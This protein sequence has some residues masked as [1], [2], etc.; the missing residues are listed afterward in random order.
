MRFKWVDALLADQPEMDRINF[1]ISLKAVEQDDGCWV[2][3]GWLDE[4][5]YGHTG[6]HGNS[7]PVHAASWIAHYGS[8]FP[9]D[10]EFDHL[11]RNRACCRPSHLEPV[12][13][14]TNIRRGETGK[15]QRDKTHCPQGHEYTE[16]NTRL[17]GGKYRVCRT[18]HRERENKRY[19]NRRQQ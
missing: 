17:K 18:C 1:H 12:S 4:D 14:K 9:R 8:D 13:T 7:R 5:G 11:C 3:P 10:Y 19:H 15:W 6:V 16:E 2:W